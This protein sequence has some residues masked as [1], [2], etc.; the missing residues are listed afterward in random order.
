MTQQRNFN[1]SESGYIEVHERIAAFKAAHPEGSLQSEI[2]ML[3]DSVV[4]MKAYAYRTPQDERPG[5]GFSSL[6]IPGSTPYTK[7]S[8]IENCETSAWGRAIAAL[9]FEVKRGIAS[10]EEVTNKQGD[11][12][13]R[14]YTPK[15]AQKSPPDWAGPLQD[16]LADRGIALVDVGRITGSP[17]TAA[18]QAWLNEHRETP[19]QLADR[20]LKAKQE[21]VPA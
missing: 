10:R 7:G 4:V 5:I 1:P 3:N 9:G 2:Y 6:G 14:S 15:A 20:A 18:I 19:V 8:E 21:A 17:T 11:A 16:A 12:G 13:T